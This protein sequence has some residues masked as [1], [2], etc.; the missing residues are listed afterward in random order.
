[1]RSS[2]IAP[3]VP[4]RPA[5]DAEPIQADLFRKYEAGLLALQTAPA[6]QVL[7]SLVRAL[8]TRDQ[9]ASVMASATDSEPADVLTLTRLD[10]V[11][12]KV[13]VRCE[14]LVGVHALNSVKTAAA[15]PDQGWWW[16]VE[17]Y[18]PRTK[19]RWRAL[20]AILLTAAVGLVTEI[21]R[22]FFSEG[23]DFVGAVY[24]IVQAGLA[25]AAGSTLVESGGGIFQEWLDSHDVRRRWHSSL[26]VL[27]ALAILVL[28][29]SAFRS[30]PAIASRYSAAGV[31]RYRE[32]SMN[33]AIQDFR[34]AI[35]LAPDFSE[36]HYSLGRAY[37][38]VVEYDSAL[39]EYQKAIE[40]QRGLYLAYNS[41]AR[42]YIVHK[43]DPAGALKLIDAGLELT[44]NEST[45]QSAEDIA[46]A[47]L[48]LFKNR[49]W[50][51]LKAG[52]L[53]QARLDLAEGLAI[54]PERAS[55][56]CLL[57]QVEAKAGGDPSSEWDLCLGYSSGAEDVERD[58]FAM[59]QDHVASR[60]A[61]K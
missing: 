2:P 53:A 56:H 45:S 58:W 44:Q 42:L 48:S 32:G 23:P 55:L 5:Q 36:A 40:I 16:D 17:A 38:A 52:N 30:L 37:E 51:N 41:L 49:G 9:L 14:Q 7:P 60:E 34:R 10:D 28:A 18:L 22:R 61:A 24:I 27:M 4:Q 20:A 46:R 26:R 8:K 57:A 21:A 19:L 35:S 12:R 47:R 13:G 59:A 50:A 29:G 15:G 6:G 33:R 25:I 39:S 11:L 54:Q 31:E 3:P 1:M 43:D